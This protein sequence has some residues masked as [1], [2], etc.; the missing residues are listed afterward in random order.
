MFT[1]RACTRRCIKT[2]IGDSAIS[3]LPS[4]GSLI[5][6]PTSRLFTSNATN[7][8]GVEADE[9]N[10]RPVD[11]EEASPQPRGTG[12]SERQQWLKS[13]GVTPADK[14]PAKFDPREDA[15]FFKKL[16]QLQD[17]L[18]LAQFVRSKLKN[19][20]FDTALLYV[21]AASKKIQC[22]VSWNHLVEWQLSKGKMN[23]ALKTYNEMKKRA[24]FPDA[25]TYTII[26]KGCSDH[27]YAKEGLQKGLLIYT[28]MLAENARIKPNTI[29]T[30]AMLRLC[31]RARDQDTLLGIAGQMDSTGLNAPNNLTFTTILNAFK[32]NAIGDPT[33]DPESLREIRRKA[34]QNARRMWGDIYVRWRK[35]D[36][37]VDEELVCAMG[38]VLLLGDTQ[39]LD[40]ILS[41]VQQAMD[42]RRQLPRM[43]TKSR[44]KIEPSLQGKSAPAETPD[45]PLTTH[46]T[47]ETD[48]AEEPSALVE[49][50]T[51][52]QLAK[53]IAHATPGQNTLSLVLDALLKMHIKEPATKYW[54]IFTQTKNVIPDSDNYHAYLRILRVFRSGGEACELLKTIPPPLV[55]EK[56]CRLAMS[57]CLR[58]KNNHHTF[59]HAGKI[60]DIMQ[61]H[62]RVPDIRT[63]TDYLEIAVSSPPLSTPPGGKPTAY[64]QG[65]Q[66]MRALERL[67]PSYLNVRSLLMYGNPT[68]AEEDKHYNSNEYRGTV[69]LL[70]RRL[71]AAYDILMDRNLVAPEMF[72][73]LKGQRSKLASYVVR[74]DKILNPNYKKGAK[75]E[76]DAMPRVPQQHKQD[77]EQDETKSFDPPKARRHSGGELKAARKMGLLPQS[78]VRGYLNQNQKAAF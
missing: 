49:N 57:A 42:I 75:P 21:R 73:S 10:Y 61:M 69:R 4:Q 27:P 12:T 14:K 40:D 17:P 1:C 70:V 22:V 58:D 64:A 32:M 13:R 39:D 30:N 5:R 24:Q 72:G 60:L 19:D 7:P 76:D 66:I 33:M 41:L 26:F 62:I 77:Q 28:S 52:S 25:Q 68:S 29:H 45:E 15:N 43:D 50:K 53:S 23:A 35:G 18:N 54:E 38:R 37:F 44:Q 56:I 3:H 59:S 6:P 65:Q 48:T 55:S 51:A 2:L 36:I 8:D 20:D 11:R 16:K 46:D 71:I 31:S 78:A 47:S 9:V 63:L 34:I 67:V 74:S